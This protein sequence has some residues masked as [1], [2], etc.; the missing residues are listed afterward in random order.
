MNV[1]PYTMLL[2]MP[3]GCAIQM[4]FSFFKEMGSNSLRGCHFK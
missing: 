1:K 4:N 2:L 3:A